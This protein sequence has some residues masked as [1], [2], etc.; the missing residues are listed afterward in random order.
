[1]R[2]RQAFTLIE[3]LVVIAI[4]AI[5]IGLLLPA[6]QKIR[7]AAARM[8]CSNNLKQLGLAIHNYEGV[9]NKFPTS[10]EGVNATATATDFEPNGMSTFVYLLPYI[11]QDNI[12]KQINVQMTTFWENDPGTVAAAKN[13][14]K[15]FLCPSDP[16]QTYDPAGYGGIDYMPIAYCN[17]DVAT[18]QATSVRNRGMLRLN[19]YGGA[20]MGSVQDGTSSTVCIIEDVGKGALVNGV[21]GVSPKYAPHRVYAWMDGDCGNGVSGPASPVPPAGRPIN[22]NA[23]PKGGPS[24][25]PWTTNNCGPNDEPFSFHSGGCLAVFG[26]GHVQ[27]L[28]D[29]LTFQVLALLLKPDDGYPVPNF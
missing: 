13:R 4:I 7:E 25:C 26:D 21:N 20:T 27:F 9:Y 5:L 8:S 11:E 15:T 22:N 2:T 10:G 17:I 18:G 6:V 16:Y 28:P 19:K 14:V 23:T 12:Y 24:S 29:T 1:M 3:L